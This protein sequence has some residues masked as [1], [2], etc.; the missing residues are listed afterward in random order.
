MRRPAAATPPESSDSGGVLHLTAASYSHE[1][2][3][4]GSEPL[5]LSPPI[6]G[7]NQTLADS[8]NLSC[9]F[10]DSPEIPPEFP[11]SAPAA[12]LGHRRY[13]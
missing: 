10:S 12:G 4:Y 3:F 1:T 13:R 11:P 5:L 9:A 8:G 6:H 2:F 7:E